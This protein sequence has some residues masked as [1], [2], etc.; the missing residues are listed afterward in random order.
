MVA[1]RTEGVDRNVAGPGVCERP[2]QSPSAR[3]AWIEILFQSVPIRR[4]RS[5]SARRAWIEIRRAKAQK[6]TEL[7]A[8]RT[9]GVDRNRRLEKALATQHVALRTEGVDRNVNSYMNMRDLEKS[10]SARRAWIEISSLAAPLLLKN[11]VALRTEGVDRNVNS[12]MNMRDLEK[13]AL[14]TEGV[15]RNVDEA[16]SVKQA[17]RSPSAR[18]AWIEMLVITNYHTYASAVALR[19]EGVDRNKKSPGV[20]QKRAGRPPHGGRG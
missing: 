17:M 12:Y 2:E 3:R 7:V 9:E 4:M 18:R 19:T 14:R 11:V 6:Q 10:P 20:H 1:L 16:D 15:D 8:L 13:V 5:P